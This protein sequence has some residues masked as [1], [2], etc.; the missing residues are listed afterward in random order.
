[1]EHETD[2]LAFIKNIFDNI[3]KQPNKSENGNFPES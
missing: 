3:L 2:R 1:M